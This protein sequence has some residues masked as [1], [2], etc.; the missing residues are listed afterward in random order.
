MKK[1]SKVFAIEKCFNQSDAMY[2]KTLLFK[3][4][5][6]TMGLERD[7]LNLARTILRHQGV[8]QHSKKDRQKIQPFEYERQ[9]CCSVTRLRTK[10]K[11]SEIFYIFKMKSRL[12]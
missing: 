2:T 4:F 5:A 7:W 10:R 12:V 3:I 8:S 6:F 11:Y 9:V 1:Q